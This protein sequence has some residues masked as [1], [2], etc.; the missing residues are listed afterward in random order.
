MHFYPFERNQNQPKLEHGTNPLPWGSIVCCKTAWRWDATGRPPFF[1]A[2]KL[3]H[4]AAKSC[5][6]TKPAAQCY[7]AC[8][9][10]CKHDAARLAAALQAGRRTLMQSRVTSSFSAV[11]PSL[12]CKSDVTVATSFVLRRPPHHGK[13]VAAF[14]IFYCKR[15]RKVRCMTA[16]PLLLIC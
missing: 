2:A 1:V 3:N 13:N 12:F 11:E 5:Y 6:T 8:P 14:F 15:T 10:C 4:G 7:N 16:R 9:C